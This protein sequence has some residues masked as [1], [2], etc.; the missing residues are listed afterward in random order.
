MPSTLQAAR[1]RATPTRL[2]P[3]PWL[4]V[5]GCPALPCPAALRERG[6]QPFRH[7]CHAVASSGWNDRCVHQSSQ[8]PTHQTA[9]GVHTHALIRIEQ[10]GP[11]KAGDRTDGDAALVPIERAKTASDSSFPQMAC[12]VSRIARAELQ[13]LP[14]LPVPT[15]RR[16]RR[17]RRPATPFPPLRLLSSGGLHPSVG[18]S[19]DATRGLLQRVRCWIVAGCDGQGQHRNTAGI[20][21]A[22]LL[23]LLYIY[24]YTKGDLNAAQL[25]VNTIKG[26]VPIRGLICSK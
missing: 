8:P 6:C 5:E 21:V 18:I 14:C 20:G 25:V 24:I 17:R 16:R 7:P 10:A 13:L 19:V 15:R 2:T 11:C 4:V 23:L 3:R 22:L 9:V 12:G 26:S 1:G